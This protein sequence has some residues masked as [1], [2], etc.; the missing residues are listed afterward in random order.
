MKKLWLAAAAALILSACGGPPPTE[1]RHHTPKAAACS[2]AGT[3][4]TV[5]A[6]DTAFDRK[7][8]AAPAGTAFTIAFDNQESLPH[9]V[10]ILTEKDGDKLFTGEIFTGPKNTTY[11][12]GALEPGTYHFHCD[13]HPTQMEGTFVVE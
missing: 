8:L 12:V 4:L 11:Q 2:P 1:E 6:K 10:A 5:V 13:V 9:N 3:A 7:C